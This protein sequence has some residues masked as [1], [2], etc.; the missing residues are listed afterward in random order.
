MVNGSVLSV[1]AKTLGTE[2]A[3]G[4]FVQWIIPVA[5]PVVCYD[6]LSNQ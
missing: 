5:Q 2:I 4:V 1:S 3:G 6:P